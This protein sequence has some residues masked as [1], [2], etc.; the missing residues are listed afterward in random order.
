MRNTLLLCVA[1]G[2]V[3]AACDPKPPARPP[4]PVARTEA[5]PVE[6]RPAR[7]QRRT[8][9]TDPP[10]QF[11][12]PERRKK[13]ESAFPA[14]E[15]YLEST[16]KRD[17]LVGLA[18]GIVIDD[19]LVWFRGWGHRDPARKL[20]VERD[21]VFGVGSISKTF[22]ALAVLKL[23]DEG[24]LDLD[25][26]ASAYLPE[27]DAIAYPTRDSPRITIRHLLTHT[28]GLPRM[29]NFPEYPAT[30][31]SRADFLATL[32]G[33]GLD[34]AP[35]ERRVYSNLGFQVLGPL[36]EAVGGVDHHTYVREQ[37]LAPLGMNHS[38]WVPEDVPGDRLAVG[39]GR[40][41][42]QEPR[43]RPHWRPGAT[44]AA[45]GMYSSVEDL[46]RYAAWLLA[47][48]PPRDDP[49]P[50]PLSRATLREA[51]TMAAVNRFFAESVRDG[52]AHGSLHGDGLGFGV[53][54]SCQF[55][56]VVAHN[57]K[58][59][60]YRAMLQMLPTRGVAVI[61]MTNLSSISSTV[62]PGDAGRVLDILAATGALQPRQHSA[63]P[64]LVAAA[65]ELAGLMGRWDEA[66]YATLMSPDY[67]DAYPIETVIQQLD[68]WRALVGACR[69]PRTVKVEDPRAGLFE[70]SCER[71]TLELELRV[72]PWSPAQISSFTIHA[73]TGL[74]VKP[75][76]KRAAEAMV[77][78][79]ARWDERKF[80]AAFTPNFTPTALRKSFADAASLWGKCRVGAGRVTGPRGAVF[81]LACERA[82]PELRIR[83]AADS[84]A[85]ADWNLR[86]PGDGPCR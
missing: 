76:V 49:D 74:E 21:T 19:E 72:T 25:R 32:D 69:D 81:T 52:P 77:A 59:M 36:V 51:Q 27:L 31:P 41:P 73:A 11:R 65:G 62:L 23:R 56:H 8:Q 50:G 58:T 54:A 45:G 48:W 5:P 17:D 12:D 13:I 46:A 24:R 44:D 70:L 43:P 9:P 20:P 39:H 29:G 79:V 35:G 26:P 63:S 38:A 61:L 86:V 34:R 55:D 75:E 7:E 14:V 53:S 33:L 85:I 67:R 15:A 78:L 30:P 47:S 4:T 60:N 22:T 82:A 6:S 83:L 3:F 64:A 66:R 37:I 57:G 71:G 84:P 1:G 28:S 40:L 18:A 80:K 16:V 2:L 10:P 68:E 42:G